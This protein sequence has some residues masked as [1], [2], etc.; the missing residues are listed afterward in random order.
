MLFPVPGASRVF[1]EVDTSDEANDG[2]YDTTE[3]Y[4]GEAAND[5]DKKDARVQ[6]DEYETGKQV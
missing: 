6:V 5:G 2:P 3:N 1:K 4:S